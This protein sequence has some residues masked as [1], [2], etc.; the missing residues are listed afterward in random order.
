MDAQTR[1][2]DYPLPPFIAPNPV[3]R[4]IDLP[5]PPS[6]N[7]IWCPGKGKSIRLS[8]EYK[9]WR[10]NADNL[11]MFN[12]GLRGLKTIATAFEVDFYFD[13]DRATGDL[14]N[15]IKAAMDWLQSRDV[16]SNDKLCVKLTA[17]WVSRSEAP[18][19]CRVTVTERG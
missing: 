15:R 17:Q 7:S 4:T 18:D 12:K 16:I 19:G 8:D 5:M 13:R 2:R 6:V 9:A 3:S 10:A 11:V 14:D 1:M